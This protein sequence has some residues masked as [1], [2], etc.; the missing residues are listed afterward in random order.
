MALINCNECEKQISSMAETCPNCGAPVTI[1]KEENTKLTSKHLSPVQ[2][3]F[4]FIV[5]IG[6]LIFAF[7]LMLKFDQYSA[8]QEAQDTREQKEL[9]KQKS[10]AKAERS[11][12]LQAE[13][14]STVIIEGDSNIHS[15]FDGGAI[16]NVVSLIRKSGYKCES[17]SSISEG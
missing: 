4:W 15:N 14:G 8:Q 11:S 10:I 3:F 5:M 9:E 12:Q 13:V 6:I 17:L 2:S 16:I 1:S 7:Q